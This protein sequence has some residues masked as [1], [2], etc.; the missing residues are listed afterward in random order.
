MLYWLY[1]ACDE[2]ESD[3]YLRALLSIFDLSIIYEVYKAYKD[4][5]EEVT[6]EI[7]ATQLGEC[8][9][10][11]IPQ[12]LLQSV[13]IIRTW[14]ANNITTTETILIMASIFAS[15][16]SIS[17]KFIKLDAEIDAADDESSRNAR[18]C[19][20]QNQC[21][22]ISH[23]YLYRS[24][25]RLCQIMTRVIVYVM[26]WSVIGGWIAVFYLC[27]EFL[28]IY[29][30]CLIA[31]GE[32][33]LA[34]TLG[35]VMSALVTMVAPL[36]GTADTVPKYMFYQRLIDDIVLM[37]VIM[38]FSLNKFECGIENLCANPINRNFIE[39]ESVAGFII[40]GWIAIVVY[41]CLMIVLK[42][43]GSWF[44]FH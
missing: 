30:W 21:F 19:S 44:E 42:C 38:Y 28:L 37:G 10:E 16:L 4:D 26:T 24:L 32:C 3:A 17:N 18:L 11:S 13:F 31:L 9:T 12:I 36:A 6:E 1:N 25:F 23:G 22:I 40:A 39:N 14:R 34:T 41:S 15:L 8:V 27:F 33:Q 29:F 7:L 2:G 5:K 35:H 43:Q 20:K